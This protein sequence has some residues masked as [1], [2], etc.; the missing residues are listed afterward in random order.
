M[1]LI[2]FLFEEKEKKNLRYQ[3]FATFV[4]K[5]QN[6]DFF[7]KKKKKLNYLNE[8]QGDISSNQSNDVKKFFF[9]FLIFTT[10]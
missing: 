2:N 8:I 10:R 4:N 7:K 3:Q 6:K 5:H 1:D 9:N